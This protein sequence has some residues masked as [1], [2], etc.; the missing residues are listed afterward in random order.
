MKKK[1]PHKNVE[2]FQGEV[3]QPSP[4][5]DHTQGYEQVTI[6]VFVYPDLFTM[7]VTV[8]PKNDNVPNC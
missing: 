1:L 4:G 3:L 7:F 2:H 5:Q 6:L 8:P